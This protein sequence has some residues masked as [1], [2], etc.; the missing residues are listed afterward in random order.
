MP[1]LARIHIHPVKSLD[2]QSV[3]EAMMLPSGA[4]QHDR[5]F[6]LRDAEGKFV[7]GKRSPAIHLLRSNFDAA[8]NCLSLRVAPDGETSQ[9][10]VYA[11]RERLNAWFSDYFGHP[12]ELIENA[13]AGFPDDT[14]APGPTVVSTGT[15][16]AV[17]Q[18]FGGLPLDEVRR[19]FRANLEIDA[20]E[21]FWED[22][23]VAEAPRVVRFKIGDAELL[24]NNPC[25]RCPVPTR[26]P[27][28][29]EV[30]PRFARIFAERREA[31]LPAWAPRDRF[32]HFYR[33]SVNTRPT[34]TRPTTIRVGDEV[35]VLG[36]E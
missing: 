25:Q 14:D 17:S 22:R 18:W 31:A 1:H 11:E 4:L 8:T 19:R 26:Q 33:L 29:G 6:A 21:S 24:G 15:M 27:D 32:D 35:Q 28:T 9:F 36:V 5:R 3:G 13:E 34:G 2:P 16:M 12:V 20:L 10:D 23:L 30:I 7:N